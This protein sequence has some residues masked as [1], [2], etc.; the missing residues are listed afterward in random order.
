[1]STEVSDQPST[2]VINYP[3][4]MVLRVSHVEKGRMAKRMRD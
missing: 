3:E 4:A 2:G 1:M